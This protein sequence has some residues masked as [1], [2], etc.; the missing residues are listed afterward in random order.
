MESNNLWAIKGLAVNGP[1]P[2]L[3][4][5]LMLLG[6]FIGDWEIEDQYTEADGTVVNIKEKFTLDGF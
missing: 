4:E 3:E 2:N 6:Q 1:D 5:K